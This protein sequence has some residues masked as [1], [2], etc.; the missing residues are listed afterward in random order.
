MAAYYAALTT[1]APGATSTRF[2]TAARL[3]R[4]ASE[5]ERLVIQAHFSFLTS[6]PG[7]LAVAETLVV[8]YPD[9]VEGYYFT[10]LGR[11]MDGRFMA[12]L[13]PL[14]RAVAM[15]SLA[16]NGDRARCL[17]C[18][19]LR[20]IVS[21]YQLADSLPAAERETRRWLR[22]QPRSPV[23][24]TLL[25]D[26]LSEEG[27]TADAVTALD[28]AAALDGGKRE[29]LRLVTL[30]NLRMYAGEFDQADRLYA[31]EIESG[32]PARALSGYW[33]RGTSYRN[34]GRLE[35]AMD[36]ARRERELALPQYSARQI[37]ELGALPQ[38]LFLEAQ[39]LYEMGRYQASAEVF[40]S[41]GRWNHGEGL[42]AQNAHQRAWSMTHATGARLA[43]GDTTNVQQRIDSVEALGALSGL[44][45]DHLLHH[46]LRGLLLALRGD[47]A[48]AV[49]EFRKAIFS[50]NF[51][52]TRTNLAMARSYLRLGRPADAVAVLQPALRGDL[53]ASNFYV[54]RTDVHELLGL[55]WDAVGGKAA[56]DSAAAHM[57]YVARAWANADSTF[58]S[59]LGR[60]R[61][62]PG[63]GATSR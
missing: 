37:R 23:P 10:G 21:A 34:Q 48:A 63:R 32:S 62:G 30:A 59:R 50:W 35:A 33:L 49:A 1:S 27:K 22:L 29:G 14:N 3:A 36:D 41:V 31:G 43:A 44:K 58:A 8:R 16:L 24:W 57:A 46:H 15:D 39:V 11:L 19:S 5:R 38:E 6:D 7:L 28:Q 61:A 53:E 60:M 40:D 9:E 51:G 56:R 2:A 45:R 13:A 17:A 26:V 52:Y 42:A 55:A 4:R 25:A 54:T 47:D 18:A 12:A 20:Q